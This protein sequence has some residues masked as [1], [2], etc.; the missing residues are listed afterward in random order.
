MVSLAVHYNNLGVD[1][2]CRSGIMMDK[3]LSSSVNSSSIGSSSVISQGR[4]DGPMDRSIGSV[5]GSVT[6]SISSSNT[7]S[8]SDGGENSLDDILLNSNNNSSSRSDLDTSRNSSRNSSS[9][10]SSRGSELNSNLRGS[11]SNP[12]LLDSSTMESRLRKRRKK[13][14]H[15]HTHTHH[16]KFEDIEREE[17]LVRQQQKE[18][19]EEAEKTGQ[20][21]DCAL[22]HFQKAL[23]ITVQNTELHYHGNALQY[24]PHDEDGFLRYEEDAMGKELLKSVN[25]KDTGI[26]LK[27][28]VGCDSNEY[29]YWKAIQIGNTN[30]L[31]SRFGSGS[32]NNYDRNNNNNNNNEN[33]H[34][35]NSNN[36]QQQ[37]QQQDNEPEDCVAEGQHHHQEQHRPTRQHRPEEDHDE[38]DQQQRERECYENLT[39]SIF[40]SMICIY[41]IALCYQYKGMTAQKIQMEQYK[42]NMR[43]N[44]AQMDSCNPFGRGGMMSS[45]AMDSSMNS[46]MSSSSTP[47]SSSS[48]S[49][50][51]TN[52]NNPFESDFS[53][54]AGKNGNNGTFYLNTAVDHYTQAYELMTRFRIEDIVQYTFLMAMMNNLAATYGSLN[55][56]T[57][58]DVCNKYLVQSLILVICSS[59]RDGHLGQEV[60][61][62]TDDKNVLRREEDRTTFES[63]LSNV[64]YLM[65]GTQ[66]CH[67]GNTIAPAA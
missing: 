44:M 52:Q 54:D 24:L 43:M 59:E 10:S 14:T 55:Q 40:H 41:N 58:V 1:T 31:E 16:H 48:S 66:R 15:T 67:S 32:G 22:K 46:C 11:E 7:S 26:K 29:I 17:A 19:K 5:T 57:R 8:Q 39:V 42:M 28:G 2:L 34:D 47:T 35:H 65:M 18:E 9:S 21:V 50:T 53:N 20:R 23:A 12:N 6:S 25:P 62:L 4:N 61:S 56:P 51:N 3:T 38:Q 64:M 60:L 45:S 13:A 27:G 63:F 49:S 33:N 37:P 30:S 36:E